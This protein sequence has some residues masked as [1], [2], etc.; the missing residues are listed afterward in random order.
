MTTVAG[1]S[2]IL[3]TA[4]AAVL[5]REEDLTKGIYQHIYTQKDS[6]PKSY[7]PIAPG[8]GARWIYRS[9]MIAF[10]IRYCI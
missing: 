9:M 8:M 2:V 6:M 3:V 7:W 1:V 5:S 10:H 4:L